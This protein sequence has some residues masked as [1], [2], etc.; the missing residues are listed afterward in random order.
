MTKPAPKFS[1]V[2]ASHGRAGL[3]VKLLESLANA[4]SLTA[5][6]VEILIVDSTPAADAAPIHEA[7]EKLGATLISGPLSVRRKRN[8]G[9]GAATGDWLFFVDSDCEVTPEI[10]NVYRQAIDSD[11]EFRAGAG[12]TV[13]QGG[14][15]RFTKLIK[16]SSLLSPFRQPA[17]AKFLLWSTTSNLLVSKDVFDA[18]NGFR[19]DFPFRLGGDDTDFCLRLNDASYRIA[20]V[21]E[22]VCH[23]S[24]ETW[25]RPS[26]VARRSFRWGWMQAILMREHP[27]YRRIDAPGLPF[28]TLACILIAAAGVFVGG[29][30]ILLAPVLFVVLA[31][32]LHAFF[33]TVRAA[34]ARA[35]LEDIALAAV[36]LPFGFGRLVGSIL[37]CSPAGLIFRL[38]ADDIAAYKVFPDTAR[39]LW[40][41]YLAFLCVAF[42]IG[43]TA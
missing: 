24:W 4:R 16:D 28:H 34:K 20:A 26:S 42:L 29:L 10:F 17:E 30:H 36:E 32:L 38:G 15:T 37:N 18:L 27:R 33:V 19:E 6:N 40:C 22:A 43:W 5:A 23:H 31:V 2:V 25:R 3:L 13:F 41:D 8:L 1:V 12:P 39:A 7:C 35:F 11:P 14:E 9:A 21:P